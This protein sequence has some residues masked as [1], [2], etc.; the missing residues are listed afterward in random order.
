MFEMCGE[1]RTR[2]AP[3]QNLQSSS[4][5]DSLSLASSLPPTHVSIENCIEVKYFQFQQKVIS[6]H[7][8]AH[9]FF[10]WITLAVYPSAGFVTQFD[11]KSTH[12]GNDARTVRGQRLQVVFLGGFRLL[13]VNLLDGKWEK[14]GN[15]SFSLLKLNSHE[16]QE[17]PRNL[18]LSRNYNLLF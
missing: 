14:L 18:L 1:G 16:R 13:L 11:P 8:R 7:S 12:L 6:F 9:P 3:Q 5:S 2:K 10:H 17:F 15:S 4:F